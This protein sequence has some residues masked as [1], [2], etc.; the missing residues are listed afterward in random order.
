MEAG[1]TLE[2]VLDMETSAR[3]SAELA[4]AIVKSILNMADAAIDLSDIIARPPLAGRLGALVG[5]VNSDGDA[6]RELDVLAED[7]FSSA[8]RRA[9]VCCYVSEETEAASLFSSAGL[10][11][12]A[13]DPLDGSSNIDVN[14]PVGSLFSIFPTVPGAL[15]DP[16][17]AFRQAGRSQV[18][19]GFFLYGPQTLLVLSTGH[20]VNIFVLSR[21]T[22]K[23]VLIDYAIS[24]STA[25]FE[26]AI[27]TS[28]Y[29]YWQEP[30]RNYID[31]CVKGIDGPHGRGFNMR[32][33]GALVADSYR[34][35]TRG[36]I[37]LYP[38]DSRKGYEQ[39]RLRLL[40]EA[41][42]IAFLAEQAGGQ[43]TDG[44]HPILDRTPRAP[45]ERVPLVMG[46]ADKVELVRRY[47][48]EI[49]PPNRESPLFGRRGLMRG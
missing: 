31:D 10:L 4:D 15:A 49:S 13:V 27:N 39:G 5:A 44:I 7:L 40:Y 28:N 38:A 21:E 32:W 19:A 48:L 18:A 1:A 12:V 47:H 24:I 11:A 34:I 2:Q 25:S 17:L 41:N 33:M 36:G 26:Y 16:A 30:V 6:Q 42:P 3:S 23:F 37:Y 22:Y 8:L 20:G 46:S 43:A 35:F 45:H 9:P 29:H 14:A